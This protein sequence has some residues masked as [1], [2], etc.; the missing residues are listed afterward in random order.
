MSK[1]QPK[2]ELRT[3]KIYIYDIW[4]ISLRKQ[5][6]VTQV[7]QIYP[8]SMNLVD[9][10]PKPIQCIYLSIHPSIHPSI[11]LSIYLPITKQHKCNIQNY[12]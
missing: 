8:C 3:T 4:I 7:N 2:L 6:S 12:A 5:L 10:L 11:Y 1:R 9:S